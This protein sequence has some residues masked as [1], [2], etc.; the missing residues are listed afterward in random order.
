MI[1]IYLILFF[2]IFSYILKKLAPYILR[3]IIKKNFEKFNKMNGQSYPFNERPKKEKKKKEQVGEY[4]DYEEIDW[5]FFH[6]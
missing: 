1:F 2:I 4:I 6:T 3:Y 5:F